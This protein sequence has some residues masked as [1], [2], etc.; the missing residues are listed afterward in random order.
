MEPWRIPTS[1]RLESDRL[2]RCEYVP[3]G[4]ALKTVRYATQTEF[5]DVKPDG[6]FATLP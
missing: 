1:R 2:R 6:A 5:L 3:V 4:R